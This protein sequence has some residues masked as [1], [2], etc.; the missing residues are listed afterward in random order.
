MDYV[1]IGV[2]VGVPVLIGIVIA[3]DVRWILHERLERA[4][5][6]RIPDA[7]ETWG[8]EEAKRWAVQRTLETG[9]PESQTED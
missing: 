9:S 7:P 1:L 2:V 5:G 8:S 4:Y 3:L 6:P